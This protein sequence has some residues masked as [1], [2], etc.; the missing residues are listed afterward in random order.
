MLGHDV[1]VYDSHS[2]AGG[3]LRFA[4]PEYRLPKAVLDREIEI[5]RRLGVKFVFNTVVGQ[6]VALND[7]DALFDAVFLSIGTWKESW[8]YMPG[9]E[10]KGVTPALPFLEAVASGKAIEVGRRMAVIGGGNAAID[11]ARTVKRMGSQAIVIYRRERRDMPAIEEEVEAAEQEGVQFMYLCAPHRIVGEKGRVKAIEVQKTRLA[12]FDQSGRRRPVSTDEVVSVQCD[13]VVL[14][15]GES[16]DLDFCAASGLVVKESGML[17]VDRYSLGT[18]R[19]KFFAGGDLI[20]GASNLSNA[21]GYGKDAARNIDAFLAGDGRFATIFPSF[22]YD[23]RPPPHPSESRRHGPREQ[24]PK[25]RMRT[26]EEAVLGL[27]PAD[28]RDEADRCL[29]CDIHEAGGKAVM[30]G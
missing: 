10:L 21:M 4:L 3:M 30:H 24:P 2:E 14:A 20:T 22:T 9:T 17:E 18:S 12:E 8:V 15:V 29:R 16:V 19:E 23:Q 13:G 6:D 26:F 28:A 27:L 25:E 11:T 5:I 1:T 7:L